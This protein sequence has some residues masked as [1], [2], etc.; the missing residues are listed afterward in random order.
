[1]EKGAEMQKLGEKSKKV[2][3]PCTL[4]MGENS[5][6]DWR[7]VPLNVPQKKTPHP[8]PAPLGKGRGRIVA[9]PFAK[10][11]SWKGGAVRC[12][13]SQ[14]LSLAL[15]RCDRERA[16]RTLWPSK[17]FYPISSLV[18]GCESSQRVWKSRYVR[19]YNS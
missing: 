18:F 15:S 13:P 8:R 6:K 9:S 16:S 12:S 7:I 19:R 14:P 3:S 5:P 10:G 11:G 4:P 2:P 17:N 1:M